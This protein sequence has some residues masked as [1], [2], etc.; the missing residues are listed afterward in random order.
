MPG[1]FDG[2]D[3]AI[4]LLRCHIRRQVKQKFDLNVMVG[5]VPGLDDMVFLPSG[6]PIGSQL[7]NHFRGDQRS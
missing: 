6:S 2:I 1:D 7:A 4:R 3:D 5:G